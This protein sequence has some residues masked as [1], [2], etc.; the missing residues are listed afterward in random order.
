MLSDILLGFNFLVPQ[1]VWRINLDAA[2]ESRGDADFDN[3]ERW[4]D[5]VE[6]TKLILASNKIQDLSEDVKLLS[7]LQS[8][9]VR[10]SPCLSPCIS[11]RVSP[12][13]AP[14]ISLVYLLVYPLLYPLV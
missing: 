13:I 6:L 2:A 7:A 4:W 14:C 3:D 11:P 12:C 1:K 9:D 5:Q 10:V 8:L